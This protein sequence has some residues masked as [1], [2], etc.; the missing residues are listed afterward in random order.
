MRILAIESSCDETAAA[1]LSSPYNLESSVVASQIEIH[2]PYGGVVPEI[3][4]RHHVMA[5]LPVVRQA[6]EQASCGLEQ[7]EAVAATRGP[8]LIGSLMVGL[9]V[10]KGI[11]FARGVPFV[12]VHHLE[13]HLCAPFLV[14]PR[15][16]LP[17]LALLVSGG[18]S[19][20]YRVDDI[21]K[22]SCLGT[23]RD[24]AAG[25]AFDK[26]AKLL[27]LG[28]PGGVVIEQRAKGGDPDRYKLPRPLRARRNLDFS[29]SG[30]KTA[31]RR[32]LEEMGEQA[33]GQVQR[34]FCA[35]VQAAIVDS[36]TEKTKWA[37]QKTRLKNLVVSG[38]VSAN[39]SLRGS[40]Q[41]LAN[42]M[43]VVAHFPPL[44]L[45]TDNGAMIA[46]AGAIRLVRGER[47]SLDIPAKATIPLGLQ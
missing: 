32:V 10:A 5:I 20:L 21:E 34:D 38:G 9:Q 44:H 47:H 8:G 45:C 27:G 24:D 22:I 37:L 1:V 42:E 17:F 18:H 13:G 30:L 6:L 41:S 2:A 23:T 29:F 28:Y 4:S 12:G 3:A 16:Q 40:I 31:A 26:V 19:G 14:E 36:L 39:Q 43:G 35:S 11:A 15:P 7:I 25:E 46:V 33:E